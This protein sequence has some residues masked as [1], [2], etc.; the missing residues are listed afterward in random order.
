M[1]M[2]CDSDI[3]VIFSFCDQCDA[4]A[5]PVACQTC[6]LKCFFDFPDEAI[7]RHNEDFRDFCLDHNC[8]LDHVDRRRRRRRSAENSVISTAPIGDVTTSVRP[9]PT[10]TSTIN[11]SSIVAAAAVI[12]DKLECSGVTSPCNS[13]QERGHGQ[14][15][16]CEQ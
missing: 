6:A 16:V 14:R 4:Q 8:G 10:Q 12:H 13:I 7:L 2:A 1:S 9:N 11:P 15:S 3:L 5:D